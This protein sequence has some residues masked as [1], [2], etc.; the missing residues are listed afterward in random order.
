[1]GSCQAPVSLR[2]ATEKPVRNVNRTW[3]VAANHH[4]QGREPS[5]SALLHS[6]ITHRERESEQEV[7]SLLSL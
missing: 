5:P 3:L 1:M 7:F 4:T 2:A 6:W